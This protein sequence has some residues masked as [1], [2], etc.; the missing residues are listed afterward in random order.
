MTNVRSTKIKTSL[1]LKMDRPGGR[2]FREIA[3]RADANL[4][5]HRD[6]VMASIGEHLE[7][8]EA[9]CSAQDGDEGGRVYQLASTIIDLAG[10]FDTGP[11]YEAAY[12]LCDTADRLIG[13]G[14]WSWPPISV[15]VR[16]MRLIL[17]EG[18]RN[19]YANDQMLK[20]L[21]TVAGA[22]SA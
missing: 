6:A 18:C 1:A 12:S 7:T 16:A 2:T 14:A 3:G 13:A 22:L 10:Y 11:L 19:S 21:R 9:L 20:G 15:H 8:L 5:E 4:E 17:A